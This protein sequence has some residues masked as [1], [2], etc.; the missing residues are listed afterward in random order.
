MG[1]VSSEREVSL[2]TG[3]AVSSALRS[4]GYDVREIDVNEQLPERLREEGVDVAWLALHGRFGEDGCVQ[5]LLEIMGIPYTGSGVLASAVAMDKIRTKR[6]LAE[7][8]EVVMARDWVLS[9]GDPVPE[10]HDFPVIV[11]PSVGGSTIG[12]SRCTDQVALERAVTDALTHDDEVLIERCIEGDEI[13]VAVLDGVAL[14]VVR[15]VTAGGFFDF[16]AKYDNEETVYEVPAPISED[17]ARAAQSAAVRAYVVL[18]CVGLARADFMV[19]GAGTPHFLEINTLPGMTETSLSPMA[20]KASGVSFD[21]LV[22]RILKS[23]H[24]VRRAQRG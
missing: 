15:I 18:G 22:E 4:R 9:P 23:A 14:P 17:V 5:G 3:K 10:V 24:C 8:A 19:D 20:A 16:D 1:G 2:K 6:V 21:E 13:T 12:M 11:K 7:H